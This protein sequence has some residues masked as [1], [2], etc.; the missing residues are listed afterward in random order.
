ML[1]K[2]VA[3]GIPVCDFCFTL[4]RSDLFLNEALDV[5]AIS[6]IYPDEINTAIKF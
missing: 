2:E 1:K 4:Y 5:Y 6:C 3:N